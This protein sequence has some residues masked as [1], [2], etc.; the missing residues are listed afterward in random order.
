MLGVRLPVDLE[1]RLNRLAAATHRS[2]SYYV[3][4][5]LE[6]Y[7]DE[8]ADI[9]LAVEAYEAFVKS[10]EKGIS[11]EDLKKKEALKTNSL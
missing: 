4:K 9:L 10:G 6:I 2:K 11:L 3:K 1:K 8:Q 5:A 7:L